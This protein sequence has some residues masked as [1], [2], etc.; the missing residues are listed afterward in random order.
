M[1][2]F[3]FFDNN[4]KPRIHSFPI[5]AHFEM[6]IFLF[7][8][9]KNLRFIDLCVYLK[10]LCC[11]GVLCVVYVPTNTTLVS[12]FQETFSL[13]VGYVLWTWSQCGGGIE[14]LELMGA[15]CITV[16]N[17]LSISLFVYNV[18]VKGQSAK[19][20]EVSPTAGCESHL[21]RTICPLFTAVSQIPWTVSST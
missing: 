16:L 12:V 20:Q 15:C 1:F 17:Y 7:Y 14:R 3:Y 8:L 4:L 19:G 10:T 9:D 18:R 13:S 21:D 6:W 5:R 11:S 2:W